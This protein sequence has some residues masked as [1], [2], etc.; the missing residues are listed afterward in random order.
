MLVCGIDHHGNL[1][2]MN[3]LEKIVVTAGLSLVVGLSL[4]VFWP[5]E[6]AVEVDLRTVRIG[7]IGTSVSY[8]P[9]YA[10]KHNKKFEEAFAVYG[11][12]VD[13]LT[14]ENASDANHAFLNNQVDAIFEAD[15]IPV[16]L[17]KAQQIPVFIAG[18]SATYMEELMVPWGSNIK[19]IDDMRTRKIIMQ[20]GTSNHFNLQKTLGGAGI[21]PNDYST[22][23]LSNHDAI[24][25]MKNES[26]DGWATTSPTIELGELSR[27]MRALPKS[28]AKVHSLLV[29][30]DAFKSG[31]SKAFADLIRVVNEAKTWVINNE[32]S[33]ATLTAD[34]LTMPVDVIRKAFLRHNWG[35]RLDE[36]AV[37]LMQPFADF[38]RD[39]KLISTTVDI[40]SQLIKN[41]LD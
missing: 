8:A 14:F 6:A 2:A 22:T 20:P 39:Q 3:A 19:T 41:N 10:A 4:L 13:Y 25:A 15:L 33:A 40:R 31:K 37:N 18:V 5:K 29:V 36:T 17:A 28:N 16:I 12:K 23:T 1:A 11:Y 32:M 7:T 30:R 24:I 27:Y 26:M 38:L 21:N 35:A 34:E 9:F